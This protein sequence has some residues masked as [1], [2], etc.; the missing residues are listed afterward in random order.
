MGYERQLAALDNRE[1]G[2][3]YYLIHQWGRADSRRPTLISKVLVSILWK[4]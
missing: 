4:L 2:R 1:D 3:T